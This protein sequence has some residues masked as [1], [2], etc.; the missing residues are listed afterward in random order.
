MNKTKLIAISVALF[1]F[2]C[3][4][5][6]EY[7]TAQ[8][9]DY[10]ATAVCFD[11]TYSYSSSRSGTCSWHGGVAYWCGYERNTIPEEDRWDFGDSAD[12]QTT[13]NVFVGLNECP[14]GTYWNEHLWCCYSYDNL[15]C[16]E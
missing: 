1:L 5:S 14:I 15:A 6:S 8:G 2:G 13:T 11:G 3:E 10:G 7:G 16:T 9:C 4:E 12:N